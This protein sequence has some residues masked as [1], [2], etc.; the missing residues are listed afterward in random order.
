M[1]NPIRQKCL[2]AVARYLEAC[3]AAGNGDFETCELKIKAADTA[4]RAVRKIV[5]R[6]RRRA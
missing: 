4:M 2:V 5:A 3:A 1:K 6:K